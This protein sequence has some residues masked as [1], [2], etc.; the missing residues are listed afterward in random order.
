[1]TFEHVLVDGE[2]VTIQ[3]YVA[4]QN[5]GKFMESRFQK[6]RSPGHPDP[7]D[8]QWHRDSGMADHRSAR[9]DDADGDSVRCLV[10]PLR[11]DCSKRLPK[12]RAPRLIL[13]LP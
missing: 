3:F 13:T 4:G 7:S 11:W 2:F 5:V 1:M 8:A 10:I 9:R 12:T 6:H